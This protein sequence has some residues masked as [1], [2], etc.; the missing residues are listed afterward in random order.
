MPS[1]LNHA[2]FPF[3]FLTSI[4]VCDAL[5]FQDSQA[6]AEDLLRKSM[7]WMDT[8]YD[9]SA[10]YMF[11]AVE[12][13][14]SHET[15]SSS[16]YAAGLLARNVGDDAEQAARI[17]HNIIGGQNHNS[18]DQWYGDYQVY[19]EQPT[20]GT[21]AY[22]PVIYN[23]W[24]PNWRGFIGT[25]FIVILEEFSNLLPSDLKDDMLQSLHLD[26]K[27]DTY[28]VGGVDDDNLYPSYSNAAIMHTALSGW[29]G[30]HTNDSN[31]TAEGERWGG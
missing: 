15:R 26:A 31:F 8:L 25:T 17:I 16:W 2:I 18:S 12:G 22:P 14:L 7:S 6:N 11:N 4:V 3:L 24:D 13:A 9:P 5:A 29:V 20:V 27:G 28:R 1:R 30:R 21:P 23:S 10:G 19:P